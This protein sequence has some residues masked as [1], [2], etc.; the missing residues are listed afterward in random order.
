MLGRQCAHR[1]DSCF[2]IMPP[3]MDQHQR[4]LSFCLPFDYTSTVAI[5]IF[6]QDCGD[7]RLF[8]FAAD[9]AWMPCADPYAMPLYYVQETSYWLQVQ[10]TCYFN[11]L[12]LIMYADILG[13][14][15]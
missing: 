8:G 1:Y 3:F 11:V 2:N 14:V 13:Y 10:F 12:I 4:A 7:A 15:H 5:S 6:L 9:L